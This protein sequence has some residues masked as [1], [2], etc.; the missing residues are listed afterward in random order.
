MQLSFGNII[1]TS[2]IPVR[3][4]EIILFI[5]LAY[6][7]FDYSKLVFL[8]GD[9]T[10]LPGSNPVEELV[11][12]HVHCIGRDKYIPCFAMEVKESKLIVSNNLF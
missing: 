1:E 5:K 4:Y 3:C 12:V 2:T 8:S 11:K 6:K 9:E 10:L 7:E